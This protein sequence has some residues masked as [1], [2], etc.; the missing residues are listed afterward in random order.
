MLYEDDVVNAVAAHLRADGWQIE[1]TALATQHG[2]DIVA[3]RGGERL[4]VEAKGEG[5]S[6]THTS[7]FGQA[8]NQ[9]QA[10]T[11]VGVAVLR[12]LRVVSEGASIAAIAL[13]DNA[14]HRREVNR[15]AAALSMVGVLVLWVDQDGGVSVQR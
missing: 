7:K 13:P 3:T 1:S 8:F 6:K 12:S 15:V 2:D 14:A 11:H 5:S 9:G 4:V 10:S